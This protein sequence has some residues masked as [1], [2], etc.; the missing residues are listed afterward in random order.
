[1]RQVNIKRL[2]KLSFAALVCSSVY[3]A[4]YVSISGDDVAKLTNGAGLSTLLPPGYREPLLDGMED[5]AGVKTLWGAKPE[6]DTIVSGISYSDTLPD[7]KSLRTLDLKKAPFDTVMASLARDMH[8]SYISSPDLPKTEITALFDSMSPTDI[9]RALAQQQNLEV[10]DYF[11][12][13][14]LRTKQEPPMILR[15]YKLDFNYIDAGDTMEAVGAQLQNNSTTSNGGSNSNMGSGFGNVSKSL[16]A[17]YGEFIDNIK[18]LARLDLTNA[19]SGKDKRKDTVKDGKSAS[20]SSQDSVVI[21]DPDNRTLLV[22]ATAA[23]HEAVLTYL[24]TINS[25][26]ENVAIEIFVAETSL[27][28][29]TD[30][31]VNWSFA[32]ESGFTVAYNPASSVGSQGIGL[33]NWQIDNFSATIKALQADKQGRSYSHPRVLTTNNR[34]VTL[35]SVVEVPYTSSSSAVVEGSGGRTDTSS[36]DFKRVGITISVVP[37]IQGNDILRLKVSVTNSTL[38]G[39]SEDGE[40]ITSVRSYG[41]A[42]SLNSGEYIVIGGLGE[43]RY[44]N[45]QSGLAFL[46]SV[47]YLGNLFGTSAI[48]NET[49]NLLVFIRPVIK[50]QFRK[51]LDVNTMDKGALYATNSKWPLLFNPN[52]IVSKDSIADSKDPFAVSDA[53]NAFH[54]L[55]KVAVKKA[56]E[57]GMIVDTPQGKALKASDT[58]E[59]EEEKKSDKKQQNETKPL[60]GSSPEQA[61]PEPPAD[62]WYLPTATPLPVEQTPQFSNQ[63]VMPLRYST[64][65]VDSNFLQNPAST[66]RLSPDMSLESLMAYNAGVKARLGGDIASPHQ[67]TPPPVESKPVVTPTNAPSQNNL[68]Q[69]PNLKVGVEAG[70]KPQ[71]NG[72]GHSSEISVLPAINPRPIYLNKEN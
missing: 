11:G 27:N 4:D 63:A 46:Q 39:Y 55:D 26:Q 71:V 68:K 50:K 57:K 13:F 60:D 49:K 38:Q 41:G 44:T 9:F 51:G 33:G 43:N 34:S 58:P 64:S 16:K 42:F 54:T 56:Q 29:T 69:M 52:D 37:I 70:V 45:T 32:S 3:A 36:T 47:P 25:P 59:S 22:Q 23:G 61:I 18:S 1:M 12:A 48:S 24:E 30:L 19:T 40:P 7:T 21:Y 5:S 66:Q 14:T 53:N 17:D 20:T 6:F 15:K 2:L 62:Y 10:I 72:A 8:I 31:G 67:V 35:E 28:P 65:A